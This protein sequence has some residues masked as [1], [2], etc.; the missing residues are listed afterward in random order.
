VIGQQVHH[1]MA[2]VNLTLVQ[3][4]CHTDKLAATARI[5]PNNR[6]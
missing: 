1:C 5:K 2:P 3:C 6:N 4:E